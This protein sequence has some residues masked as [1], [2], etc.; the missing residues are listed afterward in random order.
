MDDTV[1]HTSFAPLNDSSLHFMMQPDHQISDYSKAAPQ[2]CNIL[3]DIDGRKMAVLAL[4]FDLVEKIRIAICSGYKYRQI[5]D[6]L[7]KKRENQQ[8]LHSESRLLEVEIEEL[9]QRVKST[10]T[11]E[12]QEDD[13]TKLLNALKK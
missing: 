13:K 7:D 3:S 4:S 12:G 2:L 9:Q 5:K 1:R 10:T 8:A 11:R 6:K